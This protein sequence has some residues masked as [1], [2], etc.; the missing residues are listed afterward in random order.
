MLSGIQALQE[1]DQTLKTVKREIHRIDSELADLSTQLTN[2]KRQQLTTIQAIAKV[3][4]ESIDNG[5]L[6]SYLS[7]ADQNA[8][9]LLKKHDQALAKIEK[10]ITTEQD[11]QEQL[12]SERATL[13]ADANQ[14]AEKLAAKEAELQQ[15]LSQD[16][17]YIDALKR[18]QDADNVADE[19]ERKAHTSANSL[20]EKGKPY[21]ADDLFMYL[22]ERKYGTADYNNYNP[23]TRLIDGWIAKKIKYHHSRANYW[24]IQEIP[25]RLEQHAQSVR[26]QAD[27]F[28]VDLETLEKKALKA[29]GA[30]K[31]QQDLEKARTKIE[32]HDEK[33]LKA[34]ESL[35]QLLSSRT[36]FIAGEDIHTQQALQA[37]QQGLEHQTINGLEQMVN[38]T[39][40][41]QDNSLLYD[42]SRFQETYQD[43]QEDIQN[44]RSA[45]DQK[46]KRLKEIEDVRRNFKR[47][48]YDDMRSGFSN[49][50]VI[51]AILTQFLEGI[52]NGSELWRVIQRNQRHRDVGPWPDYGSGG[53]GR[54]SSGTVLGDVFNMPRRNHGRARHGSPWHWPNS[55]NGGFQL[56]R[57][58]RAERPSSRGG[59]KTGGG[60]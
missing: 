16:S 30:V 44:L 27:A 37:L 43:I 57:R 21:Q 24:N 40:S 10:S 14:I 5:N 20:E 54:Q 25:K 52:V 53:L 42:L 41:N 31:L 38:A 33:I 50:A 4:L 49:D 60:F 45:H 48:R 39:P 35:S 17:E 55:N 6:I 13:L 51:S 56:P 46:L 2:N 32:K 11:K 18:A 47:H 28:I 59:F 12:E 3:R 8:L 58:S 7:S 29:G 15:Q 1:I 26:K 22:W 23:L 34:E 19:A 9:S 36:Q